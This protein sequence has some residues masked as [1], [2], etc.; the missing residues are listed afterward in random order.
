MSCRLR[1][2]EEKALRTNICRQKCPSLPAFS[3]MRAISSAIR[4][5]GKDYWTGTV[6]TTNRRV[7]EYDSDFKNYLRRTHATGIDMETATLFTAGF[8][9]EIPTGALLMISDKPMEEP[10]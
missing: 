10:G 7:W 6:Y 1:L 3:M 2:S 9:N 8:A 4:D 5:R